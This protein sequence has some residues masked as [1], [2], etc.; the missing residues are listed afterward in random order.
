MIQSQEQLDALTNE[1]AK[2]FHVSTICVGVY[3]NGKT[4]F[5]SKGKSQ[6]GNANKKTVF[7]IGS[8]SKA[9]I[10]TAVM[11]LCSAGKLDLDAPVIQYLP[12]FAMYTQERTEELTLRDA[13]CH[14]SGLPRH[15]IT[16]FTNQKTPLAEMVDHIQYLEP[17]FP[18]RTKFC[19]QNHMFAL[20]SR[21]VEQVTGMPWGE[22]VEKNILG[23]L[24]MKRTYTRSQEYEEKDVNYAKPKIGLNV[25]NIPAKNMACDSTGAAGAISSCAEDMLH[26]VKTNLDAGQYQGKTI[27]EKSSAQELH[28]QQMPIKK[29]DMFTYTLSEVTDTYYG[30]GWFV[31][32]F[33]GEKYVHHG[34]SITG[35]KSGVGFIPSQDF[36]YCIL[37]N[38]NNTQATSALEYSLCDA[39]M[40][41]I[42]G[43][44]SKKFL[45]VERHRGAQSKKKYADIM[46]TKDKKSLTP[47][48][49]GLYNHPAYGTLEL[50]SKG[51][52]YEI[53]LANFKLS[54]CSAANGQCIAHSPLIGMAFPCRFDF[55]ENGNPC[56]CIKLE[57]MIED[58]ICFK[59]IEA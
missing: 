40:G 47:N 15:D 2:Q 8:A 48:L 58:Y 35:F 21:V 22:Y 1:V 57:E 16:L 26:W 32:N 38:R 46:N 53:K 27:F 6:Q 28:A 12:D 49:A 17:A 30:L 50:T 11:Q 34:G 29:G 23:E 20:A 24:D 42:G 3:Q 36:A 14:R 10:A 5:S 19:Y 39:A 9:F 4:F 45:A 59:K 44:W 31:E 56:F 52:Q 37:T 43:E 25:L 13:L 7:P 18:A 41:K 33:H 54:V 55:D 51:K